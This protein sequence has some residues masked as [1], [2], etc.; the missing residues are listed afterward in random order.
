MTFDRF[1][2][3]VLREA[4]LAIGDEMFVALARTSQSPIIYEVL[5]YAVGVTD[6][7]GE[8]IAQGNGVAGFLGPL[9]EAVRETL[10]RVPQL[11]PGDVV[12][13]NDPYSGGGTHPSDVTLVRPVFADGELIAFAAAS[14]TPTSSRSSPPTA[15]CPR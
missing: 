11:G 5:D 10:V 12:A 2:A 3:D 4:F 7:R 15:A 6:A 1:T 13:V 14:S 9:G 8:L